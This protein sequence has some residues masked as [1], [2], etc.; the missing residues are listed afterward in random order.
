MTKE[1]EALKGGGNIF[2]I[3]SLAVDRLRLVIDYSWKL[4]FAKIVNEK[5]IINKEASMQLQLAK[6]MQGVGNC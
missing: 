3:P 1:L 6:V 2:E 5:L 4:L